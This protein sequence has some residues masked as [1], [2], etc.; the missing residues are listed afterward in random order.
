MISLRDG[1]AL[2]TGGT[3]GIGAATAKLFHEEGAA[4]IVTGRATRALSQRARQCPMW[5]PSSPTRATLTRQRRWLISSIERTAVLT[6][7]V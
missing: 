2:I 4:V 1:V 6:L 5:R 3:S 7:A